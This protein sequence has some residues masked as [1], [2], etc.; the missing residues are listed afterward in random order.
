MSSVG[1]T[2]CTCGVTQRIVQVHSL[3]ACNLSCRHCYSSSGPAQKTRLETSLICEALSDA[4]EHGHEIASFAGGEPTLDK[5]LVRML[6]HSHS[7]GLRTTVTTNGTLLTDELVSDLKG[8][9][10][11]LAISLDGQPELH[12]ELRGNPTSYS[13]MLAGLEK[14]KHAGMNF[15]FIFTLTDRSWEHLVWAG[16]FAAAHGASLLQIHPIERIGRG[17]SLP[18]RFQISPET[19]AKA[20]VLA[21][22]MADRYYGAMRIQLDLFLKDYVLD[23][24]RS[25]YAGNGSHPSELNLIVI[26]AN[27]SVVPFSYGFSSDYEIGNLNRVRLA[28]ALP[29][30]FENRFHRLLQLCTRIYEEKIGALD[31]PL[32]DWYELITNGSH[33]RLEACATTQIGLAN[34]LDSLPAA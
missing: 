28:D 15:G 33:Q 24:P 30:F 13:R 14:V 6:R 32:F 29:E 1:S 27:G 26:Q 21:M 11:V 3:L 8:C 2:S 31:F 10:D 23:H 22:A 12:N 5:G 16:E 34:S 4:A 25:V 9:V 18:A 20:Y 7:C 19:M 17:L